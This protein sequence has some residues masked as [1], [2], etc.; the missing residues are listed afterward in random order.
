M[1]FS[2]LRFQDHTQRR[3]AAGRTPLDWGCI[4]SRNVKFWGVWK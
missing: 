3:T 4:S 2:F 1:A